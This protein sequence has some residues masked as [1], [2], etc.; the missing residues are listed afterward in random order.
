MLWRSFAVGILGLLA[1]CDLFLIALEGNVE[2]CWRFGRQCGTPPVSWKS[3]WDFTP[4][5][6]HE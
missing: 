3:I 6:F 5:H 1:G 4:G 2:L